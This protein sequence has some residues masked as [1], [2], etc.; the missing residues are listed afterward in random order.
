VR[1][2]VVKKG[3][4]NFMKRKLLVIVMLISVATLVTGCEIDKDFPNKVGTKIGETVTSFFSGIGKGI[5]KE[6]STNVQLSKE[7]TDQGISN[8]SSKVKITNRPDKKSISVYLISDKEF[9]AELIAKAFDEEGAE[10]G[11]STVSAQI[12]KDD[13]KYVVFSFQKEIDLGLVKKFIIDIK[14]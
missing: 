2:R 8:T 6:K 12:A 7:L 3:G 5:N 1:L 4:I 11:R 13:A 10:I 14:K 9:Q